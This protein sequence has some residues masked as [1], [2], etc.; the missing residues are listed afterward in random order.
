MVSG[1]FSRIYKDARANDSADYVPKLAILFVIFNIQYYK[2]MEFDTFIDVWCSLK[3][4]SIEKS[5]TLGNLGPI[6]SSKADIFKVG[7]LLSFQV[8]YNYLNS[9]NSGL[10]NSKI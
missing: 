10:K 8:I 5:S 3:S 9:K 6:L 7:Y 1:R 4:Y 2:E